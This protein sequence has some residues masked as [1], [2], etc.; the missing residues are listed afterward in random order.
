[1]ASTKTPTSTQNGT[2]G[3]LPSTRERRPALAALAVLLIV[4][5]ALA[6]A[7][8][9]M[10]SGHRAEFVQV[11]GELG[12]GQEITADDLDTVELPEDFEGGVPEADQDDLVGKFTTTPWTPGMVVTDSMFTDKSEQADEYRVALQVDPPLAPELTAGTNVVVYTGGGD[13]VAGTVTDDVSASDD[14]LGSSDVFA[15]ISVDATCGNQVAKAKQADTAQVLV[16]NKP[17]SP[18]A[19]QTCG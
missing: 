3:R 5:G 1:M 14:G 15:V 4:G 12:Q 2:S 10:Q 11:S 7:W 9:A 13:G 6:S 19:A 8:L 16:A 18:D 17:E